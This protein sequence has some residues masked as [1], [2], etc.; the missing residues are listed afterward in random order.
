M[1]CS[2]SVVPPPTRGWTPLQTIGG[3]PRPGSPAHAGMDPF[4]ARRCPGP[5]GFPRPRGDGPAVRQ[6]P[7]HSDRVPPPTRGWTR[8]TGRHG[9][10]EPGSPAHAGMDPRWPTGSSVHRWVPP[11]TRGWTRSLACS[12]MRAPGSPAHAGMDLTTPSE[13]ASSSRFPRPRGDGPGSSGVRITRSVVPPPTRGWTHPFEA[14]AAVM[15]GSPAHAG[16]DPHRVAKSAYGNGFPRPRGDGP[17]AIVNRPPPSVVPPPTRG[18]TPSPRHPG[19]DGQ[20]SPAHA[21]MDFGRP[22][23]RTPRSRFPRPRGDG[24][25]PLG[26]KADTASVP[27]PTR[28]W[29]QQGQEDGPGGHGSPA[30]AGMDPTFPESSTK[31][32]RFPRPRGDGPA[33]TTEILKKQTVPPPTRGWTRA[34]PGG[35]RRHH[36]S[37]AHAGMDPSSTPS[38]RP[39]RRFPRPRGDGP[40]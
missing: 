35:K 4:R 27:P 18:W 33:G 15:Q 10:G 7:A 5:V 9:P 8:G 6:P 13:R 36:G 1:A 38:C 29:T 23:S 34:D 25:W 3:R 24:P 28:G 12:R 19:H 20:G 22:R 2:A 40:F 26:S 30:H 32:W 11:P 16:M 14:A 31:A 17:L 39:R 37:P 21:G